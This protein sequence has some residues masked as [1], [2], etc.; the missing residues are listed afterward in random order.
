MDLDDVPWYPPDMTSEPSTATPRRHRHRWESR[1]TDDGVAEV[2]MLCWRTRDAES[3]RRS[4]NNRKRGGSDELAVARLLGGRKVGQLNLPWDVEVAGYARL[5]CKQLDVWPPLMCKAHR[6]KGHCNSAD[7]TCV[8]G[9]L[10]A[11][12]PAPELRGVTLADTPGPGRRTRRLVIFYLD[13]YAGWH[14]RPLREAAGDGSSGE[15][16]ALPP[17]TSP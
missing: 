15:G 13:E 11:I 5:Q 7:P 12:P 9:L 2:C 16:P 10:D 1:Q 8:L 14:G 6:E 17:P 4:R 3:S